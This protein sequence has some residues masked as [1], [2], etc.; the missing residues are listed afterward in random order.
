[1]LNRSAF[2]THTVRTASQLV[3]GEGGGGGSS[4]EHLTE[5]EDTV[6]LVAD[7]TI[8]SVQASLPAF[9]AASTES[10]ASKEVDVFADRIEFYGP[11]ASL[12]DVVMSVWDVDNAVAPYFALHRD[13]T[14]HY[15]DG[16]NPPDAF[17]GRVP[18]E[19][20]ATF[21]VAAGIDVG[22]TLDQLTAY[23]EGNPFLGTLTE[24]TSGGV[25]L[26]ND[27]GTRRV[28]LDAQ[29]LTC[30]HPTN[31]QSFE[32][33]CPAVGDVVLNALGLDMTAPGS[34]VLL[35]S[36]DGNT[37][38]KVAINNAGAITLLDP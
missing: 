5:N 17:F 31:P 14:Q 16:T 8:L 38:K 25:Q 34:Y 32:A 22:D 27:N 19:G 18:V 37:V 28:N 1:M 7:W 11:V 4:F 33:F 36:P 21:A 10:A 12:D 15:G 26:T 6:K 29:G 35:K 30:H 24:M 2:K 3:V 23:W 9:R 20:S 13:G